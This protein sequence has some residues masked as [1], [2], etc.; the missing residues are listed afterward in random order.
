MPYQTYDLRTYYDEQPGDPTSCLL[1]DGE[2]SITPMERSIAMQKLLAEYEGFDYPKYMYLCVC[3]R[4]G[5]W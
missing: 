2:L 3:Q 5:W 1:C 4:C